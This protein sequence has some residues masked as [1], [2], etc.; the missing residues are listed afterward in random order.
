MWPPSG[1]S[2]FCDAFCFC[3]S[4]P[5]FGPLGGSHSGA[6]AEEV[7]LQGELQGCMGSAHLEEWTVMLEVNCRVFT[8]REVRAEETPRAVLMP[9]VGD[10]ALFALFSAQLWP[11]CWALCQDPAVGFQWNE[12]QLLT[13]L[14]RIVPSPFLVSASL[15]GTFLLL[16]TCEEKHPGLT[17]KCN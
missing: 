7:G 12:L 13:R 2:G 11:L 1:F 6:E 10:C 4:N 14:Q 17:R 3:I 9:K 16:H 5:P 15:S 8:C